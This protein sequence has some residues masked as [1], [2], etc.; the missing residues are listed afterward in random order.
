MIKTS[1][2]YSFISDSNEDIN[3]ERRNILEKIDRVNQGRTQVYASECKISN[4]G[5]L[6]ASAM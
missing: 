1:D 6:G 3:A 4:T 5:C 2:G